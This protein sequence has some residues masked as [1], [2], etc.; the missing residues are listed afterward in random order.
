MN[1]DLE[2]RLDEC[3]VT[4]EPLSKSQKV[5]LLARWGKAFT[6]L[7]AV[8]RRGEAREGVHQ[9]AAAEERYAALPGGE[10]FVLPDDDSAMS[11]CACSSEKPPDLTELVSDTITKCEELVVVDGDFQWSA[12][13]SNHGSPQMVGRYFSR[14]DEDA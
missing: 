8:A 2:K 13:F 4:Y 1:L 9:D 12:V 6:D 11:A 3:G 10:Y 14:I 5:K 7:A